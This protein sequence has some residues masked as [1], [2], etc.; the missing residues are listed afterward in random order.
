M[1][2]VN[3]GEL[4]KGIM[5]IVLAALALG[6]LGELRTWAAREAFRPSTPHVFFPAQYRAITGAGHHCLA[7]KTRPHRQK[8]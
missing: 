1:A 7:G 2:P 4:I 6:H 8:H 5:P 3:L